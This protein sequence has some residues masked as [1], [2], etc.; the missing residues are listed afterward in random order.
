MMDRID[1]RHLPHS[2]PA[3]HSLDTCL[4]VRAPA[5]TAEDTVSIVTPTHRQTYISADPF[6]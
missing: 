6:R 4:H 1:R 3:P 2:D 5:A